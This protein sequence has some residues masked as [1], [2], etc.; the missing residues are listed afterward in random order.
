MVNVVSGFVANADRYNVPPNMTLLILQVQ[1]W[2]RQNVNGAVFTISASGYSETVT[3]DASG[4]AQKLVPSGTTYTVSITIDG[5]YLND[6]D[7]LATANSEEV[8]WVNFVLSL[9]AVEAFENVAASVW[10]ADATYDDYPYRCALALTGVT[11]SDIPEVVFGVQEATSGDYAPVAEC[12]DGGV[13][14]WSSVDTAITVPTVIVK[15][16]A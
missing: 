2:D 4:R 9:S 13:Y 15:R 5:H 10:T 11:A 14:I 1:T 8:V 3:A 6:Q 12:Y 16:N 7:Q